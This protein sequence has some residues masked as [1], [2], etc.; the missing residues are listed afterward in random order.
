MPYL[1]N[2]LSPCLPPCLTL[3]TCLHTFPSYLLTFLAYLLYFRN[4]YLLSLLTLLTCLFA[5]SLTYFPFLLHSL[6]WL[7]SFHIF[8]SLLALPAY[9]L[10]F[11]PYLL[12]FSWHHQGAGFSLPTASKG[13]YGVGIFPP[14]AFLWEARLSLVSLL[15]FPPY[16]RA[17]RRNKKNTASTNYPVNEYLNNLL[18]PYIDNGKPDGAFPTHTKNSNDFKEQ[19]RL[20][21][22]LFGLKF[23]GPLGIRSVWS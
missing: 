7:H 12:S 19:I 15:P 3:L 8:F 11:L 10:S 2:V 21:D 6:T 20:Q 16:N 13:C 22:S 14:T 23:Q 4:Q 5:C 1:L 9:V 18:Y 17:S